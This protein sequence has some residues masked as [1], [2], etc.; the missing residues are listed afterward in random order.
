M[1]LSLSI[2]L[3]RQAAAMLTMERVYYIKEKFR[4]ISYLFI[5]YNNFMYI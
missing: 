3:V 5:S 4:L 2:A 1:I